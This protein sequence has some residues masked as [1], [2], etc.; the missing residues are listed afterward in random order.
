MILAKPYKPIKKNITAIPPKNETLNPN[1]TIAN[2]NEI[3]ALF[4]HIFA[5]F[6]NFT[7]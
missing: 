2:T 7:Y 3:I 5:G 4:I 6:S 1:T